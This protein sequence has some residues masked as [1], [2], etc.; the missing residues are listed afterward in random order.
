M[1]KL[2][3]YGLA[4]ALLLTAVAACTKVGPPVAGSAKAADMLTMLPKDMT[5]VILIDVNRAMNT[6]VAS[7]A[8]KEGDNAQ[9]YQD[10]IKK[11]GIDPQKDVY[12][13][14]IG[15]TGSFSGGTTSGVGVVN[16][17]YSKDALLAKM[18][19]HGAKFTEGAYEGV[20]TITVAEDEKEDS[21]ADKAEEAEK[22]DAGEKKEAKEKAEA[23]EKPAET[24]APEKVM[25]GAFLDASNI[26]VGPE[27][28]VKAAIDVL[29]KKTENATANADLMAQIKA[30]NKNAMAWGV[31]AF[32]AEDVKKMVESTPML[33]SLSSLKALILAFDYSNKMLDI[34]IKAVTSE[35][36]K[37]K[38][39]ADMLNGFKAMGSMA[40]GNKPEVGELLGK[41][42][43][44]SAADNVRI[45]AAVP[46]EL[47]KKLGKMA[48]SE[49]MNKMGGGKA[50]ATAKGEEK[51]EEKKVKEVKK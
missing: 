22:K 34:E 42:E 12:F 35:A 7:K 1:K 44:T 47:L 51:K 33:S 4:L 39:I 24:A 15:L 30:V 48:Q 13:V 29:K 23:A 32:K 25:W 45:H 50:E 5:G 19:D 3:F 37:N 10:T 18:K 26:A 46:E 14:A 41:I 8:L 2:S 11:L 38:E 31:F 6:E 36:G 20:A 27:K 16:L 9:K 17:K 28:E 49:I 43:I 21:G 40:A